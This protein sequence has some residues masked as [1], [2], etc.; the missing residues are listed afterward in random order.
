[1]ANCLKS[2][3]PDDYVIQVSQW[4]PFIVDR[5]SQVPSEGVVAE[6]EQQPPR[7]RFYTF[8]SFQDVESGERDDP[9]D[10][11]PSAPS[12]PSNDS[13]ITSDKVTP[14]KLQLTPRR[15]SIIGRSV[16]CVETPTATD[17]PL[18]SSADLW[19]K[20]NTC[21]QAT[22]DGFTLSPDSHGYG[23]RNVTIGLGE[24]ASTPTNGIQR[25]RHRRAVSLD[26]GTLTGQRMQEDV[27]SLVIK[28][29]LH[30]Y[31]RHHHTNSLA[32]Q[33]FF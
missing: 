8:H 20:D 26:P 32:S 33:E 28:D 12:A 2:D 30:G 17:G 14:K 11:V 21:R 23:G 13:S 27:E 1:M 4:E 15:P 19:E 3:S 24:V 31:V 18:L 25:P 22:R 29:R 10:F 9:F 16:S 7:K 5:Q 6:E